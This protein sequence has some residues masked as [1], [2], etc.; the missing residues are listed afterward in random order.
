[1]EHLIG[2]AIITHLTREIILM[3]IYDIVLLLTKLVKCNLPVTDKR[4]L[5]TYFNMSI[6]P[7]WQKS[8]TGKWSKKICHGCAA[9]TYHI[10]AQGIGLVDFTQINKEKH[11]KSLLTI[12]NHSPFSKLLTHDTSQMSQL[13]TKLQ[14]K[15]KDMIHSLISAPQSK[16]AVCT[17]QINFKLLPFPLENS[18]KMSRRWILLHK[19]EYWLHQTCVNTTS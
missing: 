13:W 16:N 10:C 4:A 7:F 14:D 9:C 6:M 17:L 12:S 19:W 15:P 3:L 18:C 2:N 1:M 5:L 11:T 8:I